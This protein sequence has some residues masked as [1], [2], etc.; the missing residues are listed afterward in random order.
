MIHLARNGSNFEY[1]LNDVSLLLYL[2]TVTNK[3]LILLRSKLTPKFLNVETD[4]SDVPEFPL[5]Q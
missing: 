2:I 3:I 1:S 4:A 5:L